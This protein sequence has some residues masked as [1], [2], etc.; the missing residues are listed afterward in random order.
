MKN[1][2]TLSVP[3]S[4]GQPR[5]G[6]E[7]A[8]SVLKENGFMQDLATIAP[9]K[10]LGEIDFE[11]LSKEKTF[12]NISLANELISNC[13]RLE[14]LQDSFLL[15]VGGDHGMALGTIHGV[16]THK[17]NSIVVW[18][19]AHGD[20]NTPESSVTGNFHGMPLSFLLG[21][22]QDEQNFAWIKA[23]LAPHRLIFI[24]PRDL[25]DAE[26]EIIRDLSIQYYSSEMIN[27]LGMEQILGAAL[28]KAD[29]FGDCPI[30]LSF[31]VDVFDA[32]DVYATGTRVE[33]GPYIS[34]IMKMG[35]MLAQTGRLQSMDLVEINP[36]LGSV[37]EVQ[38]T[39]SLATEF[40]IQTLKTVFQTTKQ[41]YQLPLK[42]IFRELSA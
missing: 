25:D 41:A 11:L 9:V 22:A 8:M 30:H 14:N 3:F 1:I 12:K 18:A 38:Q 10:D 20:I 31:D 17:R 26:K 21:L 2:K 24:G 34:E 27:R 39:I 7:R 37:M 6:V 29:P 35:Q 40:T 5:P 23:H 32:A 4:Y 36:E 13:I 33:C 28:E 15:N 42:S 16:L 19:D